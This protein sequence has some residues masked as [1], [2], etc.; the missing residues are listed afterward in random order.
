[1]VS[2]IA[3]SLNFKRY[4]DKPGVIVDHRSKKEY[5][6][7]ALD[8]KILVH[9]DRVNGWFFRYGRLLEDDHNAGFV[10]LQVALAQIE[11]MEQYRRG[12][13]SRGKSCMFFRDGLKRIFGFDDSANRWLEDF[14]D[15]VR[16]GLF[17][18]GMTRNRVLIENRFDTALAYDGTCI[19]VSPNK[20]LDAVIQDF[21]RYIAE[22]KDQSNI[23]LREDFGREYDM[24][25]KSGSW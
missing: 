15:L 21:N 23:K 17:H 25:L 4:S 24:R 2:E 20:F 19:R 8:T 22:L 6:E 3:V 1:M 18:D 11:G 10:V 14:Y 5:R 12:D 9:E 16:C 7:D 13:P